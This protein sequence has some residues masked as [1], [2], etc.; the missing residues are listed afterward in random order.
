MTGISGTTKVIGVWGHPVG[1]SLSPAMHNAA[2]QA[3]GLNW[4]YVPFDVDPDEI[5]VEFAVSGL[6]AT[7]MVGV[8]VTVPLKELVL[9]YTVVSKEALQI[10][11]VNTIHN[12]DGKLYGYSTDGAGFLQSLEE[13]GQA[14]AGRDVYLLGAGGSARAVAWA[15][16]SRGS[17]CWIANRTHSRSEALAA[18]I[19]LV[20][21]GMAS[22]VGW[23]AETEPSDLLV[24]TTSL[25]MQPRT[26]EMPPLPPEAFANKPFVC[27]LIYAPAETR[28]LAEAKAAGCG[29][30]NGLGMLVYQ[31]AISLSI[32]TG[33]PLSE[34][35]VAVMEQ[36]VR[37][38]L[39]SS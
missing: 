5:N 27:D 35:P 22:A 33:R 20:Y 12:K 13:A 11:S 16:A 21:P 39:P 10:G 7:G 30:L 19:N 32:W 17:R 14:V 3:L 24:N 31:G 28:L 23:G 18:D 25:G 26:E 38:G 6:R 36:A 37:A 8:N 9:P 4:V 1:H 2:L 34:M 29:T 15:L